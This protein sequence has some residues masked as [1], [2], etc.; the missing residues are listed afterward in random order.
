MRMLPNRIGDQ[1][2][3]G[4]AFARDHHGDV[5]RRHLP[6]GLEHILHDG[7]RANNPFPVIIDVYRGLVIAD[8]TEIGVG[9]Q[10]FRGE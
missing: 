7:C 6:D 1:L 9:L 3:A 10:S 5:A 2:F 4:A 8:S